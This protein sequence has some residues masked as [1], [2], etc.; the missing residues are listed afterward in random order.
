MGV[1]MYLLKWLLVGFTSPF[2]FPLV[3]LCVGFCVLILG[4]VVLVALLLS[5]FLI[6]WVLKLFHTTYYGLINARKEV[7]QEIGNGLNKNVPW[8]R[9]LR[10]IVN[11]HLKQLKD[12]KQYDDYATG[13]EEIDE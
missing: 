8:W 4:S 10:L 13:E 9:L 7:L 12:F 5:F 2:W 3:L 1:L 6:V 11:R